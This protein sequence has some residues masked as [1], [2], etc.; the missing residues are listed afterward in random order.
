MDPI[1]LDRALLL[2]SG[3]ELDHYVWTQVF[4]LIDQLDLMAML[5]DPP[6]RN[7]MP[8]FSKNTASTHMI[9]VWLCSA[10]AILTISLGEY[11][12]EAIAKLQM[13]ERERKYPVWKIVSSEGDTGYGRTYQEAMCKLAI[14]RKASGRY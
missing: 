8:A 1:T 11:T 5:L 9:L 3:L 6:N 13:V 14:L 7:K 10:G 4:E 2:S 12:D